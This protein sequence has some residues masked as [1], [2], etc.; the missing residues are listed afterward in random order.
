MKNFIIQN[1]FKIIRLQ[2]GRLYNLTWIKELRISNTVI[3]F[4]DLFLLAIV[5]FSIVG[6][7]IYIAS[8]IIQQL[9]DFFNLSGVDFVNK[10]V[11][12]NS[13][14]TISSTNTTTTIIHND[15]SWSNAI[16]TIF[17]YGSGGYRLTLLKGGG[18]PGSRAFVIGTTILG[19]ALS[20]V[21]NN[22]INDPS[23]VRNQYINWSFF[24]LTVMKAK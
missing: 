14:S 13:T 16:R 18:T 9:I 22:T 6:D 2:T 15:G 5:I 7:F 11:E 8:S 23:Y 10:M 19:D 24:W 20:K 4:I 1:Y 21:V 12:G 17:I 3:N